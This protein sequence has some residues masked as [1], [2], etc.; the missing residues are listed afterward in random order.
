[1]LNFIFSI[2]S[3][4]LRMI[5]EESVACRKAL[6]K[7]GIFLVATNWQLLTRAKKT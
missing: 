6:S 5:S 7:N 4:L 3:R 2:P 1:V